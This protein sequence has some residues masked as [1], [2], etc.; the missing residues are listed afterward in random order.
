MAKDRT[1][2]ESKARNA[3]Q[4]AT[5]H[6]SVVLA[7]GDSESP[8]SQEALEKLCLTYWFPLYA[9]V[10]RSGR[11]VQDAEDLTQGFLAFLLERHLLR[12]LR[13]EGGRFRS[14][15]LK[16]FKNFVA[17]ES[18]RERAQKRGGNR[19][20]LSLDFGEAEQWFLREQATPITPE[21]LY[22]Q[23]WAL[24]V[25]AEVM[26]RIE[27][28]YRSTGRE[29]LFQHLQT[30]LQGDESLRGRYPELAAQL[31]MT[32]NALRMAVSRL[33][34]RYAAALRDVVAET[35]QDPGEVEPEVRHLLN[36]LST[37]QP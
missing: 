19:Q 37:Q 36:V 10:R 15:L 13:T 28:E 35:V 1:E 14:F 4:F 16:C 12:D 7:A 24:A 23:K 30:F 17:H 31:Q 22:D 5:T 29:G 2:D 33:R 21:V 27:V 32:Q 9:F 20:F 26:D 34:Q 3:A 18:E 25:L 8:D 11:S 6:W